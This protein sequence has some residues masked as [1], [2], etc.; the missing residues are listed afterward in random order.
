[1]LMLA[2]NIRDF[3]KTRNS[4][5]R[6]RGGG[7]QHE[8]IMIMNYVCM[9]RKLNVYPRPRQSYPILSQA[10]QINKHLG[11]RDVFFFSFL[12][13]GILRISRVQTELNIA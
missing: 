10:I 5:E 7:A 1:M 2:S 6:E 8:F 4:A 12:D 9:F 11:F 13:G 3:P